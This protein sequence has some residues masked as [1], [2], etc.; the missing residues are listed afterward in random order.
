MLLFSNLGAMSEEE[1]KAEEQTRKR[2]HTGETP[3][4]KVARLVFS[5]EGDHKQL[6]KDLPEAIQLLQRVHDRNTERWEVVDTGNDNKEYFLIPRQQNLYKLVKYVGNTNNLV[7]FRFYECLFMQALADGVDEEVGYKDFEGE[8]S[9]GPQ[10]GKL[11][12]KLN[13]TKYYLIGW[14]PDN[15]FEPTIEWVV[16]RLS[17]TRSPMG[18][19]GPSSL[20]VWTQGEQV[21]EKLVFGEHTKNTL[22]GRIRFIFDLRLHEKAKARYFAEPNEE[23][24]FFGGPEYESTKEL[25]KPGGAYETELMNKYFPVHKSFAE[26][27]EERKRGLLLN[28]QE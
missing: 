17:I 8:V 14:L 9:I 15:L 6:L 27:E 2:A 23:E 19:F 11:R 5:Q 16:G 3:L 13:P 1:L 10:L 7:F 25:F 18:Y 4:E 24:N 22:D 12:L 26:E 28:E 21:P 20:Y